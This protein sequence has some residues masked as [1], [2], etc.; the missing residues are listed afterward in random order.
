MVYVFEPMKKSYVK[1]ILSIYNHYIATSTATFS[2]KPLTLLEM[3]KILFSGLDRFVSYA[4]IEDGVI[5]GYVLLNRYKPREAYDQTAEVTVYLQENAQGKGIGK[6][7]LEFI[8]NIAIEHEFRALLGVICAEN[9]SSIQL[10]KKLGYF[11]CAHFREVGMKFGRLL[12]VVIY[13]K[14]I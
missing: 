9:I 8:E 10:F 3:E 13:E 5:V 12:D 4:I 2:I 14:L 1:S 7:A 6:A 11:E